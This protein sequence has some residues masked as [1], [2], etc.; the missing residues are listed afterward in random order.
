MADCRRHTHLTRPWLVHIYAA[1]QRYPVGGV[2]LRGAFAKRVGGHTAKLLLLVAYIPT[3]KSGADAPCTHVGRNC[4]AVE[5][6]H[7]LYLPGLGW[8]FKVLQSKDGKVLHL[9]R[10]GRLVVLALMAGLALCV[11]GSTTSYASANGIG[12]TGFTAEQIAFGTTGGPTPL[13]TQSAA[14]T[15]WTTNPHTGGALQVR[16]WQGIDGQLWTSINSGAAFVIRGA[17]TNV[18]PD[19]VPVGQNGAAIFHTGV[20][21]NIYYS[22]TFDAADATNENSWSPWQ[23]IPGATTPHSPSVQQTGSDFPRGPETGIAVMVAYRGLSNQNVYTTF[24]SDIENASGW[25]SSAQVPGALTNFRPALSYGNVGNPEVGLTITGTDGN[26][27]ATSQQY[28]S[29]TW[30]PLRQITNEGTSTGAPST[31]MDQ[32]GHVD[33]T[34]LRTVS[35]GM[36]KIFL[37]TFDIVD[38]IDIIGPLDSITGWTTNGSA[39]AFE[40]NAGANEVITIAGQD[41]HGYEE[42][43]FHTSS[44]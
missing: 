3:P 22:F 19:V 40:Q 26:V 14:A 4:D 33:L 29:G 15:A 30:A 5:L 10:R 41:F 28:G 6:P 13:D 31:I 23:A 38:D 16:T 36:F 8:R 17:R 11:V 18:Q 20:D 37:M 21:N 35:P 1:H 9:L 12:E 24:N 42:T 39:P 25:Q 2:I 32:A 34:G 7:I 27:W 43:I 44:E